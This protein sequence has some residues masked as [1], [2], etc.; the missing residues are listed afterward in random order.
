MIAG[1]SE[2]G[3]V[4]SAHTFAL[5]C[6]CSSKPRQIHKCGSVGKQMALR[7]HPP[8]KETVYNNG[9]E[10]LRYNLLLS[11]NEDV[12]DRKIALVCAPPSTP[13]F[14]F[15]YSVWQA[16]LNFFKGEKGS[17]CR[18][19]QLTCLQKTKRSFSCLRSCG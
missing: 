3:T 6:S 15:E 1:R 7:K 10:H 12:D 14:V 17:F 11:F 16:C 5:P 13:H 4:N 2:L 9:L 8:R 19:K 18:T